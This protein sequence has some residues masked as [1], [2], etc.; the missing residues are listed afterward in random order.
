MDRIVTAVH[1]SGVAFDVETRSGHRFRVEGADA[2][3][4]SGA[5]PME[6]MLVAVATC[7]GINVTEILT[8]MRQPFTSVEV[9]VFGR[10][11]AQPPR[12]WTKVDLHYRVKG[13]VDPRRLERAIWLSDNKICSATATIATLAEVTSTF[14][15]L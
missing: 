3:V 1:D 13:D 9:D 15:I 14:E 6:L 10:R 5:G 2:E 11:A 8:K 7:S 12:V 4:Q